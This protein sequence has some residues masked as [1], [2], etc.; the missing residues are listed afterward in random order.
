MY[1]QDD[2]PAFRTESLGYIAAITEDD[3]LKIFEW[4]HLK[5]LEKDEAREFA[6]WILEWTE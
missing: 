5:Q 1:D 3:G 6:E 2:E 4:P